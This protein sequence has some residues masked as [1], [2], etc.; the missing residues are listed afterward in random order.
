MPLVWPR[1]TEGEHLDYSVDWSGELAEGELIV[2][3]T[4]SLLD[5]DGVAPEL[6]IANET[7]SD[8]TTIIWLSAGVAKR[9]YNLRNTILSSGGRTYQQTIWLRV[10]A[11]D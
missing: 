9:K 4:W 1:K 3:S 7:I 10:V 11:E 6:V 5:S 2:T 8:L